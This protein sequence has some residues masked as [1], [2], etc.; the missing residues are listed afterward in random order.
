MNATKKK[1]L[2]IGFLVLV[3]LLIGVLSV[4]KIVDAY[5]DISFYWQDRTETELKVKKY[6][7]QM[8]ISYG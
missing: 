2:G 6:A 4:G 5:R 3:V 8:G 1:L 7:E